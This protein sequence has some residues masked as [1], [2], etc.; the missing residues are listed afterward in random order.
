MEGL[1]PSETKQ[2]IVYRV[3]PGADQCSKAAFG[4]LLPLKAICYILFLIKAKAFLLIAENIKF[5]Y[6]LHLSRHHG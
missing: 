4:N 1:A 3:R 5:C 6:S 2:E